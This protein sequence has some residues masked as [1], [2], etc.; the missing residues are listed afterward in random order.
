M[1]TEETTKK[2]KGNWFTNLIFESPEESTPTEEDI[3]VSNTSEEEDLPVLESVVS[4][5]MSVPTSGDGV[6]DQK[7]NEFFQKLIEDSDLPGIDYL[8]FKKSLKTM[9]TL[10]EAT[11]YQMAFDT[12]KIHD[13]NLT[14]KVILDA[15]DHYV[16]V[17]KEE[18]G[19]F[20]V[21]MDANLEESVNTPRREAEAKR[22]EN[23]NILQEIKNLNEKIAR[24]QAESNEL[25]QKAVMAEFN[26]SQTGKNFNVTLGNVIA[27]L[28]ADKIKIGE[29]VKEV[30]TA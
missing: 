5:T 2:K 19:D 9:A 16:K 4:T 12:S 3:K 11:R 1:S 17:L 15:V 25:D 23:Q 8:E 20:K 21:E 22:N 26:I 6:F 29:L 10:P 27:N 18:E 30:K 24:N 7:F 14:K 13:P 28:D